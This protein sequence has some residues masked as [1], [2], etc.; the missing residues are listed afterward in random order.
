ML[1]VADH[2]TS[3]EEAAKQLSGRIGTGIAPASADQVADTLVSA[4]GSVT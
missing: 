1:E 4:A 2:L 3:I